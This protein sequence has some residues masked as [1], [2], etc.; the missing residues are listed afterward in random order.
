[1]RQEDANSTNTEELFKIATQISSEDVLNGNLTL[2]ATKNAYEMFEIVLKQEVFGLEQFLFMA[3][4]IDND[5][6]SAK[7][8]S[9]IYRFSYPQQPEDDYFTGGQI[10]GIIL[11]CLLL[12]AIIGC[13]ILA[14][15]V[16]GGV[17]KDVKK[18]N[19]KIPKSFNIK[20]K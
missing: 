18:P 6:I 8:V 2:N 7:Q 19:I 10:F 3:K 15:L 11:G 9:N 5:E 17:I 14:A 20:K 4:A 1:M 16:Y 13:L 12:G